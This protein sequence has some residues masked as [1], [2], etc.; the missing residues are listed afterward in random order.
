MFL[1]VFCSASWI[2]DNY[3]HL[4]LATDVWR[5]KQFSSKEFRLFY[6]K[7]SRL[8]NFSRQFFSQSTLLCEVQTMTSLPVTSNVLQVP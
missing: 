3:A 5:V 7:H 1:Y 2:P 6:F 8:V 4:L